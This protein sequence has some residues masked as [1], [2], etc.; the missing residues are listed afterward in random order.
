MLN[1]NCVQKCRVILKF[2][3][4]QTI[5]QW[6]KIRPICPPC[7]LN[8]VGA[9]SFIYFY[10][11]SILQFRQKNQL[12]SASRPIKQF[13]HFLN[14]ETI[15]SKSFGQKIEPIDNCQSFQNKK[16]WRFKTLL[17][18]IE[19]KSL[20]SVPFR[21]P[22]SGH[23]SFKRQTEAGRKTFIPA[24]NSERGTGACAALKSSPLE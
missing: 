2:L 6:A 18:F 17:S 9:D 1:L 21:Q 24:A 4:K 5:T 19:R 13:P 8:I 15:N 11:L 23:F 16:Q 22:H 3:K 20:I 12:C 7:S 14:C 10:C